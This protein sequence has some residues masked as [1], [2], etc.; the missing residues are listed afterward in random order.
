MPF[1]SLTLCLRPTT[2]QGGRLYFT[3][4][5][6]TDEPSRAHEAVKDSLAALA[7]TRP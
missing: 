4:P 5:P 1:L 7:A 2:K 3:K 6:P